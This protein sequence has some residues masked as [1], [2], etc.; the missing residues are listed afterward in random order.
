MQ[1]SPRGAVGNIY[2]RGRCGSLLT[3]LYVF[4]IIARVC[5]YRPTGVWNAFYG[6]SRFTAEL[7]HK[8]CSMQLFESEYCI[9]ARPRLSYTPGA[10]KIHAVYI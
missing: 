2:K 3:A 5:V 6:P 1:Y 7:A 8:S 9:D 4:Y 10:C